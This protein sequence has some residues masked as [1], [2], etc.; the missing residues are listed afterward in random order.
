[1]KEECLYSLRFEN[2]ACEFFWVGTLGDF[3]MITVDMLKTG[4]APIIEDDK[5]C[6]NMLLVL[7]E[8][9]DLY[10]KNGSNSYIPQW[11]V[12][13]SVYYNKWSHRY[14]GYIELESIPLP[15]FIEE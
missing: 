1:M 6:V 4:K 8:P 9:E 10:C 12:C 14:L 7:H 2:L 13:N 15:D 3:F 11:S 5:G